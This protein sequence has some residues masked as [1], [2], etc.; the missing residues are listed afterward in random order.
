MC[1]DL[2]LGWR[3]RSLGK[4]LNFY[5]ALF[6]APR[7]DRICNY[8]ARAIYVPAQRDGARADALDRPARLRSVSLSLPLRGPCSFLLFLFPGTHVMSFTAL[9]ANWLV[10]NILL[11]DKVEIIPSHLHRLSA[12]SSSK[13]KS[14]C[15]LFP[16]IRISLSCERKF[17]NAIA[18]LKSVQRKRNL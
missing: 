8:A 4:V 17:S 9:N 14:S 12:S 18:N 3:R 7:T 10:N 2:Q 5:K 16:T 6:V 11:R 13:R 1:Y 15:D